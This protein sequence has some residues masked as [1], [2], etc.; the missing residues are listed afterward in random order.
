MKIL[1]DRTYV[2]GPKDL[3]LLAR[4]CDAFVAVMDEVIPPKLMKKRLPWSVWEV[5]AA[6]ARRRTPERK[7]KRTQ[8]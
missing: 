5:I 3:E 1:A 6:E 7:R 2:L 4:R 8:R